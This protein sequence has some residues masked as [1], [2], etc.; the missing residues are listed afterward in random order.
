MNKNIFDKKKGFTLLE[1]V[2]VMVIMAIIVMITLI[3]L[4]RGKTTKELDVAV[5]N[6]YSAIREAQNYALT[7][8]SVVANTGCNIIRFEFDDNTGKFSIDSVDQ[9]GVRCVLMS[10]YELKNKVTFVGSGEIEFSV[11]SGRAGV[12]GGVY[13]IIL[14]KKNENSSVCVYPMGAIITKVSGGSCPE[15]P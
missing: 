3:F 8:Q 2:V 15:N 1:L 6:V 11:P 12:T 10:E 13:P 5:N 7:G 9:S 4:G 14:S